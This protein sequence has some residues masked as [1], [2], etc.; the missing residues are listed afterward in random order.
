MKTI[1]E[2]QLQLRS[3]EHELQ[4]LQL[5]LE[6]MK[7]KS[8]F[9][10]NRDM[11]KLYN[12]IDAVG[13]KNPIVNPNVGKNGTEETVAYLK[14][15]TLMIPAEGDSYVQPLTYLVR[16]AR[17]C[18]HSISP[19]E[20]HRA[21]VE[22]DLARLE[23]SVSAISPALYLPLILDGI[24]MSCV[25]GAPSS[26]SLELLG[27]LGNLLNVSVGDMTVVAQLAEV[28]LTQDK[29][30]FFE[31]NPKKHYPMLGYAVPIK[32]LNASCSRC[33]LRKRPSASQWGTSA[34]K[35]KPTEKGTL[36][37]RTGEY[38]EKG[39][40]VRV[41]IRHGG[42]YSYDVYDASASRTGII[43]YG[44]AEQFQK[45]IGRPQ[46]KRNNSD[47]PVSD[48]FIVSCFDPR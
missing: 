22:L 9:A 12:S 26:D 36:K 20:L 7:P 18:N 48:D 4:Q 29:S 43:Q 13:K 42:N 46:L 5:D 34:N 15:L 19:E 24:M 14:L 16:I 45:A 21:S 28:L 37:C 30:A 25:E 33:K 8:K 27:E 31:L 47:T 6:L 38:V 35:E 11:K 44:K 32:W 23:Q 39:T 2:I 41:A 3:L 1:T 40:K 17:G 10:S